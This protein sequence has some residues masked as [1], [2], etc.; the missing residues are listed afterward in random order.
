MDSVVIGMVTNQMA[1]QVTS[2]LGG[3]TEGAKQATASAGGL[4]GNWCGAGAVSVVNTELQTLPEA[5]A[6][7]DRYLRLCV[8]S[9][10]NLYAADIDGSSDPFVQV[11]FEGSDHQTPVVDNSLSPVWDDSWEVAFKEPES[12][13]VFRVF[14]KD[15]VGANDLLGIVK[16]HINNSLTKVCKETLQL[17]KVPGPW[18]GTKPDSRLHILYQIVDTLIN[19]PN[20]A[21]LASAAKGD[22]EPK[23]YSLQAFLYE[24]KMTRDCSSQ[25]GYMSVELESM[26]EQGEK[27]IDRKISD[28]FEIISKR[29]C[30]VMK[31]NA[32]TN[33]LEPFSSTFRFPA[34]NEDL[35]LS[36]LRIIFFSSSAEYDAQEAKNPTD[37]A[38]RNV[39]VLDNKSIVVNNFMTKDALV[40]AG[41][42]LN[43]SQP[44]SLGVSQRAE[45]E[46]AKV[47]QDGMS[48]EEMAA[49]VA[50]AKAKQ[51]AEMERK[52]TMAG[53]K[54][55]KKKK[56]TLR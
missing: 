34:T 32:R 24:M 29:T 1:N 17:E 42:N 31:A 28:R 41:V 53:K 47:V 33:A 37:T 14:D 54:K 2:V 4:F 15:V 36:K 51:K 38:N 13:I 5:K 52:K 16:L 30:R 23:D 8:Q 20:L 26:D 18:F 25:F 22:Q 3:A 55:K 46:T 11:T 10:S 6:A 50:E 27:K 40:N 35:L 44:D 49:D 9:A 56:S 39:E 7:P 19:Q 48:D 43:Q 21:Q 45:H 12:D